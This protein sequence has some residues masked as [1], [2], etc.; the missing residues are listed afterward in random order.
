[1]FAWPTDFAEKM[2]KVSV[3][4]KI[5]RDTRLYGKY[6]LLDSKGLMA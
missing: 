1:M 4:L 5:K 3:S 2:N 6:G